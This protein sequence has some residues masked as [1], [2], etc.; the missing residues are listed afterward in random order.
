MFYFINPDIQTDQREQLFAAGH[1]FRVTRKVEVK[2]QDFVIL[3][4]YLNKKDPPEEFE[5]D[6]E[7]ID[8]RVDN[9]WNRE[10]SG[11]TCKPPYSGKFLHLFIFIYI[12]GT[13]SV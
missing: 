11:S 10:N 2:D 3:F 5:I 7:C 12:F 13:I 4:N 6:L 1:C 8:P 9:N